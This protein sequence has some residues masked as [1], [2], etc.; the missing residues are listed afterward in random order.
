MTLGPIPLDN[1]ALDAIE[2]ALGAVYTFDDHDQALGLADS[3]PILTGA[4]YT[5]DQLLRFWSGADPVEAGELAGYA[6]DSPIYTSHKPCYSERDLLK[7]LIAEVRRL[8]A[9]EV[10]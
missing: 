6:G 5:L 2:H 4:D 1:E 3:E 7:A 10:T 8:R 9:K